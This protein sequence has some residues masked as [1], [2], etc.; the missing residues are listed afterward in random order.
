[1]GLFG[2]GKKREHKV[3]QETLDEDAKAGLAANEEARADSLI[4]DAEETDSAV[5]G[6]YAGRGVTRGPWDIDDEDVPNY[7][8]YLDMGS[9]YLPF[10][11]RIELRVKANRATGAVLGTTITFQSSSLEIEAYAAPKTLGLWDDVRADLLASNP[12]ASEAEGE[13]GVELMLPVEVKGGRSVTTRIVGVDGPRWMLRGIFSGVAATDPDAE[14]TQALNRFFADIVVDRGSEP[15]A[16][17]DLIPMHPP[18]APAE[19]RAA[20]TAAEGE[21]ADKAAGKEH[22]KDIPNRPEG[23]LSQDQETQVKTT[24]SRGPMFSEVR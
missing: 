4:A 2:F 22:L 23:P 14:E 13:F 11:Q 1:M 20:A 15:L 19:R 24:L 5:A 7:D 17:R 9:Y 3:E 6:A 10:M 8:D 16:P 12:A 18:V 21:D